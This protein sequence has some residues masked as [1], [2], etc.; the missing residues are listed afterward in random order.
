MINYFGKLTK[1]YDYYADYIK[2]LTIN[3]AL[4]IKKNHR[5]LKIILP[6]LKHI[7]LNPSY[8]IL[9]LCLLSFFFSSIVLTIKFI[10]LLFD[11]IILS[12]LILHG[13]NIKLNARKLS[14]NVLSLFIL[15]FNP[16]GSILTMV[17]V[18]ILYSNCSKFLSNLIIKIFE[19]ITLFVFS[20]I[21][22]IKFLYPDSKDIK[23]EHPIDS[24]STTNDDLTKTLE[25]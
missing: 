17:I 20:S 14:K 16:I 25:D 21:P 7:H 18:T 9:F 15:Y 5:K 10:F 8:I 2:N 19:S 22:F 12:L 11:S 24:S 1:I 3:I 23:Y 13:L 4:Y 6:F